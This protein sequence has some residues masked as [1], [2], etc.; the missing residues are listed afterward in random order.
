MAVEAVVL[1]LCSA[2]MFVGYAIKFMAELH[3]AGLL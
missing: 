3:G 1:W 2:G